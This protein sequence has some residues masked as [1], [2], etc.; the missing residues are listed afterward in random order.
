MD[1]FESCRIVN[2]L[3]TVGQE[4]AARDELIKLLAGIDDEETTAYTPLVNRLIRD[5]GLYPYIDVATAG[6]ED[7]Y[8]HEA[9]K[10]DV[11]ESAP[12]TLHLEQ[13]RLLDG[14]LSGRNIAVS[15]PTSFGKSFV[16]DAFIALKHPR[17]VVILVPTIALADETRRRLQRKFG[18]SYKIITTADQPIALANIF[19]FPQERAIG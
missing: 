6:W 3:L 12:V 11:G 2:S 17:N 9:F 10:T 8:V 1:V 4:A 16:I 7:R 14:L 13:R 15:A 18:D 5:V 19:I